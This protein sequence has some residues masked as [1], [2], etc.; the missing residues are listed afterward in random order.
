MD[1]GTMAARLTL[2]YAANKTDELVPLNFSS[3]E[4]HFDKVSM[5]YLEKVINDLFGLRLQQELA[6]H[7]LAPGEKARVS[8]HKPP[9]PPATPPATLE[10]EDKSVG[11][12]LKKLFG[13]S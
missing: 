7:C 8:R 12:R 6:R 2:K 5:D 9:T 1:N 4:L 3:P 13:R 11:N 10:T